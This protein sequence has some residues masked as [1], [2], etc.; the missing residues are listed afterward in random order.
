MVQKLHNFNW[1][2]YKFSLA[3]VL[4]FK[5]DASFIIYMTN[6]PI[7]AKH[8]LTFLQFSLFESNSKSGELFLTCLVNDDW[9]V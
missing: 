4:N 7:F 5:F 8:L 3:K 6:E 2:L 1:F 9:P